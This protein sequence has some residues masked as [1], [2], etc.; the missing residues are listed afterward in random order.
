MGNNNPYNYTNSRRMQYIKA[1]A[2]NMAGRC[3]QCMVYTDRAKS[4]VIVKSFIVQSVNVQS[5]QYPPLQKS[6]RQ[7]PSISMLP[8]IPAKFNSGHNADYI[9][10][11]HQHDFSGL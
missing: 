2:D 8:K 4:V 11:I 6:V 3:S 7:R 1:G 10:N 5:L 9:P